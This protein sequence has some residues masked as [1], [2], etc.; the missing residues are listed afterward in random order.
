MDC[1]PAISTVG[2][3]KI[4]ALVFRKLLSLGCINFES[5]CLSSK[6][7]PDHS[8]TPPTFDFEASYDNSKKEIIQDL[9]YLELNCQS[10]LFLE[11]FIFLKLP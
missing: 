5:L 4:C 11:T 1:N 8:K 2:V 6:G 7:S 10:K 9:L 3:I